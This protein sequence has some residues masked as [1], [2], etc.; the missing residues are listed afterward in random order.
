M[1]KNKK[2]FL[3]HL[4]YMFVV[5]GVYLG[6]TLLSDSKLV[7]EHPKLVHLAYGAHYLQGTLRA[8]VSAATLEDYMPYRRNNV[9]MWL[10]MI[11]NGMSLYL[12]RE[13]LFDEYMMIVTVAMVGWACVLHQVYYTIEDFKRVLKIEMFSIK[14][15]KTK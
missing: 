15:K 10:L 2:R 3:V 6:Y 7:S 14:V 13:A 5:V 12:K 1:F 4:S 9:L 11:V 8:M